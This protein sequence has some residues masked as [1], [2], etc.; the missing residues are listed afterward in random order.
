M[1]KN[2]NDKKFMTIEH[3]GSRLKSRMKTIEKGHSY[4]ATKW[5]SKIQNLPDKQQKTYKDIIKIYL[6]SNQ[7]S[8]ESRFGSNL[9][10][11]TNPSEIKKIP[12]ISR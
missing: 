11:R 5:N 4:L 8:P 1:P 2:A 9:R 12:I 10:F 7:N 6:K 3:Q